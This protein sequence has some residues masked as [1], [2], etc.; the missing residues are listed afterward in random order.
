MK[1]TSP[2]ASI[3]ALH[4][5][6]PSRALTTRVSVGA[7]GVLACASLLAVPA[8]HAQTTAAASVPASGQTKVYV[9]DRGDDETG[10][11]EVPDDGR[12]RS[13][14]ALAF[15]D[16]GDG[17]ITD[18]NTGLMWEKKC[19][20]CTGPHD[21]A[22]RYRWSGD[23]EAETIWDWIESV[24]AEG[25][26]GFA[27][28]SDWRVPNV[29]ELVSIVDYGALLP[30]VTGEFHREAAAHKCADATPVDC[31]RTDDGEYWTSTTFAD[32]PAHALAVYFGM[33]LVNDRV[34][35]GLR[36]VRAVRGGPLSATG[37]VTSYAALTAKASGQMADVRDDGRVRAG[38]PPAFRDNGDGTITD[39]ATGLM[40]EKKCDGCGGLHD[41]ALDLRWSGNGDEM[42]VWDWQ[43]KVNREASSGFAG[44]SDWRIPNVK[45]LQTIVDYERF[46]PA[47]TRT[48][49]GDRC[50]LGCT[51][52]RTA[53][54]SCTA[55]SAYWTST[56]FAGRPAD[57]VVVAFHLGLIETR[58]KSAFARV[59]AVRGGV[60]TPATTQR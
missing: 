5:R 24:N 3:P 25:D 49:D 52:I 60:A 40:W 9:A 32:F 18:L 6:V 8:A 27:G 13:G 56:T 54:C 45:E 41:F 14:A 48:F 35:T 7:L 58:A 10:P 19:A 33:G 55:M 38:R 20:G 50:G 57:A 28:Y 30:A 53:A 4:A 22:E 29:R 51:D 34:K 11:V 31:S 43:S 15:R 21:V 47:V 26:R 42:T 16:N 36:Y 17:T 46:N 2:R 1:T 59:R 23:G 44:H 39:L 37:Q 12:I